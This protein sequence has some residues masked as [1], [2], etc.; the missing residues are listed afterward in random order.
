MY[1]IRVNTRYSTQTPDYLCILSGSVLLPGLTPVSTV[2]SPTGHRGWDRGRLSG[3]GV[4]WPYHTRH[5]PLPRPL[6]LSTLFTLNTLTHFTH[7]GVRLMD[8]GESWHALN[9]GETFGTPE[10][11]SI[12]SRLYINLPGLTWPNSTSPYS[13]STLTRYTSS[14]VVK[15]GLSQCSNFHRRLN[16]TGKLFSKLFVRI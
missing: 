13:N 5:Q 10:I 12:V 16:E 8:C 9:A 6:S 3:P 4:W 14:N 2:H 11:K 15:K 7:R 1:K